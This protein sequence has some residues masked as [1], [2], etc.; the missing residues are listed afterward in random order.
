MSS[1]TQV[2]ETC[3]QELKWMKHVIK[4]SSGSDMSSRTQVDQTCH[5]EL[6]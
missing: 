4:N 3:H 6:K 2:D 5:Q 1:R